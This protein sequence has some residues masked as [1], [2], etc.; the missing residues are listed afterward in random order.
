MY[1]SPEDIGGT[2][3]TEKAKNI[4]LSVQHVHKKGRMRTRP[5]FQ[6]VR[7]EGAEL[8]ILM[9]VPDFIALYFFAAEHI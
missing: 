6:G 3:N 5:C 7:Q 2:V 4:S 9:L 8:L 1:F